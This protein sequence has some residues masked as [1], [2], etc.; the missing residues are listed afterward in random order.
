MWNFHG[1]LC[2]PAKSFSAIAS[3]SD[4]GSTVFE[5]MSSDCTTGLSVLRVM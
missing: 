4:P 1:R 5:T 2:R 3:A